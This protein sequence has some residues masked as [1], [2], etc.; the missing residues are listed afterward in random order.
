MGA[1]SVPPCSSRPSTADD[2]VGV[3]PMRHGV[4]G[5]EEQGGTEPA[6]TLVFLHAGGPE[7]TEGR[8]VVA[9][10]A[11]DPPIARGDV[12][13][14]GLPGEG[15]LALA[16]PALAEALA[17]PSDDGS[18]LVGHGTPHAEALESKGIQLRLRVGQFV[19]LHEKVRHGGLLGSIVNHGGWRAKGGGSR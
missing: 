1:G 3:A 18:P 10:E 2:G 9:R 19:E 4:E 16:R 8:G 5:R 12:A 13:R 14:D 17:D 6:P 15:D 7:E 11:Q